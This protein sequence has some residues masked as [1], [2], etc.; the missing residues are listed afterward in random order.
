MEISGILTGRTSLDGFLTE[1]V[2]V[3]RGNSSYFY[4]RSLPLDCTL[5]RFEFKS[6]WGSFPLSCRPTSV[7]THHSTDHSWILTSFIRTVR[8]CRLQL[9]P[10]MEQDGSDRGPESFARKASVLQKLLNTY[11]LSGLP[12]LTGYLTMLFQLRGLHS[13]NEM[14]R[15]S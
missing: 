1:H 15:R 10:T 12:K 5:N 14:G 7:G 13:G 2:M 9:F 6:L 8:G 3:P 4:E 11:P